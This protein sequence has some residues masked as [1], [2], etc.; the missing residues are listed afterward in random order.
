MFLSVVNSRWSA[1]L[2]SETGSAQTVLSVLVGI[3]ALIALVVFFGPE[4]DSSV[5]PSKAPVVVA[6]QATSKSAN[7]ENNKPDSTASTTPPPSFPAGAKIV[8]G[9]ADNPPEG[10]PEDLKRA[11]QNN[12][13]ELPDDIKAQAKAAPPELPEDL[14]RQLNNQPTELPED[15]QRQLNTPPPPIPEDIRRALETPPRQVTID[16][17]NTPP[18]GR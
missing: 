3:G 10:L 5:S 16:E 13:P 17:V 7:Q 14:R 6:P 8:T 1:S 4:K 11:L 2:N 15:L 12:N 18:D 9:T